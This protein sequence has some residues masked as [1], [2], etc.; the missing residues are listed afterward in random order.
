V[1]YKCRKCREPVEI[2]PDDKPMK[3]NKGLSGDRSE[4]YII[5]CPHCGTQNRFTVSK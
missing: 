5:A 1:E 3:L 4:I 2:K